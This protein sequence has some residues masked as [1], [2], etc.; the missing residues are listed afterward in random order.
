MG[1]DDE[2]H[3]QN[4]NSV[5]RCLN[6]SGL[7]LQPNKSEFMQQLVTFMG[8]VIFAEG[9]SPTD[10]KWAAQGAPRSC[11]HEGSSLQSRM[12]AWNRQ[13]HRGEST[14]KCKQPFRTRKTSLAAPLSPWSWPTASWECIHLG[15]STHHSNHYLII[16]DAHSQQ[17]EV[18]GPM[19]T[20]TT[21]ETAYTGSLYHPSSNS[22][23]EKFVLT[24]QHSLESS[25]SEPAYTL[26]QK[27]QTYHL[28]YRFTRHATTGS[29]PAK[30]FLQRELCTFLSLWWDQT[31]PLV[32]P[33]SKKR[34]W[35]SMTSILSS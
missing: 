35:C 30:L 28:S 23:E 27:I 32:F 25:A 17:P 1:Q 14:H 15:F 6:S 26:Q 8:C 9:I 10:F 13:Q 19:K 4:L 7:Q 33:V 21:E 16:I 29:F 24:F 18:I 22:L 3:I 31:S 12:V 34:W 11:T 5:L 2:R 20:T